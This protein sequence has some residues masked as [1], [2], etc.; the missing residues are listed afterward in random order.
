MKKRIGIFI[1]NPFQF[2]MEPW[3]KYREW[4]VRIPNPTWLTK[5]ELKD[6]KRKKAKKS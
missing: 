1:N 2:G 3:G 5:K 4:I 6:A